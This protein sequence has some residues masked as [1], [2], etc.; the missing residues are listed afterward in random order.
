MYWQG[1]EDTHTPWPDGDQD[2]YMVTM[3]MKEKMSLTW[4]STMRS[5]AAT[6]MP[7]RD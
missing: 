3:E 6:A 4:R 7:R 2:Y 1:T 5:T